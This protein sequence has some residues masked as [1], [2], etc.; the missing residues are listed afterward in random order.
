ME[1][2]TFDWHQLSMQKVMEERQLQI[3]AVIQ[4]SVAGLGSFLSAAASLLSGYICGEDCLGNPTT[5]FAER[6][7]DCHQEF[8]TVVGSLKDVQRRICCLND[9]RKIPVY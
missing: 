9:W 5:M 3:D 7:A 6:V 4:K 8:N 1:T 2:E